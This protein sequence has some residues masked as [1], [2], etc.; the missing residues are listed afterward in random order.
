MSEST[1]KLTVVLQALGNDGIQAYYT[2]LFLDYAT[3][4]AFLGL[5]TWGVRVVWNKIKEDF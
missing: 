2:Y 3:F 1:E 5:C 4:W